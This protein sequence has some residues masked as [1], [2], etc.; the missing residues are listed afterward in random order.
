[1]A[2]SVWRR[3][4][5][6]RI[7]PTSR[8]LI[9]V[10]E[11]THDARREPM[12]KSWTRQIGRGIRNLDTGILRGV[13]ALLVRRQP[14]TPAVPGI[15]V[16]GS[17]RSGSTLTYQLISQALRVHTVDNLQ[18]ALYRTP[19]LAWRLSCIASRPYVSDYRSEGGYVP[20]L[21]GPQQGYLVWKYWCDMDQFERTPQ[22]DPRRLAKFGRLVNAVCARD[23]RAYCAGWLGHA[24]YARAFASLFPHHVIVRTQRGMLDT[25][26]SI[27]KYTRSERDGLAAQWTSILPRECLDRAAMHALS[28]LE[29]VAHQVYFINRRLHDAQ[30]RNDANVFVSSYAALCAAPSEF[31]DRLV[32]FANDRGVTLHRR[33]DAELPDHFKATTARP[34]Q[35][36]TTRA[37]VSALENLINQYG[38]VGAPIHGD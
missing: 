32:R 25:A 21:N 11:R 24:L 28:P 36:E 14:E 15:A 5:A 20:G 34:D 22:P 6:G 18:Y 4:S 17:P 12:L 7:M 13:E 26:L 19:Y 30:A 8:P 33:P 9:T 23:G 35:D 37:L 2:L 29:R 38:D 27:A 3:Q 1:M 31:V 16:C 10:P